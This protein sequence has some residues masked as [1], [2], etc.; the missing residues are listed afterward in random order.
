MLWSY[1]NKLDVSG[2]SSLTRWYIS[3]QATYSVKQLK[4]NIAAYRRCL[5]HTFSWSS[6]P[7]LR[8]SWV[9]SDE[10]GRVVGRI[11]FSLDDVTSVDQKL[12]NRLR[13]VQIEKVKRWE[14][15]KS[16]SF[17]STPPSRWLNI[18]MTSILSCERNPHILLRVSAAASMRWRR[19]SLAEHI[20]QVKLFF[21]ERLASRSREA[22]KR[23]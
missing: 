12:S 17:S 7:L 13:F 14:A 20:N 18:C 8:M 16:S 6:Y 23:V 3:P 1:R 9:R 19:R 2:Q 11:K 22:C 10:E 5:I 21:V 15:M 4:S